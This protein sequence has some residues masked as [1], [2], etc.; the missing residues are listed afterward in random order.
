MGKDTEGKSYIL[1][2]RDYHSSYVWLW[3]TEAATSEEAVNALKTW[4]GSFGVMKWLLRDQGSHFKNQLLSELSSEFRVHHYFTTAYSP[5][6]N[7]TMERVCR[8]VL[9]AC[10]ALCS[11][12]K[13]ALQDWAAVTECA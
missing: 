4:T 12:W 10:R 11:E 7:G 2:I 6:A 1:I 5:W 8:E 13:L 3:P 9:R